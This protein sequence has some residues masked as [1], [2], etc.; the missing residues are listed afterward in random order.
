MTYTSHV[1]LIDNDK[2]LLAA[3]T[4]TLELADCKV[5]AFTSAI[6]ALEVINSDF[7]GVVIT[8]IRMPQLDG[9]EFFT[10][11]QQID[12][13]IPVIIIT[14]HGDIALA[15][16][17][18]NSG[19]YDFIAKPFATD[20]LIQS[21]KRA[22]KQRNL[23]LENRTMRN[24]LASNLPLLG[25]NSEI[26]KL[27]Q[28]IVQIAATDID[29]LIIGETGTGKEVVANALHNLSMRK[30]HK[31]V[32]LNCG[33]L[34]ESL[35]ESELF[36][37]EI[38]AFTGASKKRI[39]IIEYA[40]NGTLFL[41]EVESMSLA[42]QARM[43]R[44]L[45]QREI[46]PLGSNHK[47][48]L[49][50][51]I[52]AATKCDLAKLCKQG[53]F[54]EDL[55]YRLAVATIDIPPLRKR[56]SDIN[57]LYQHFCDLASKKFDLPIPKPCA[58]ISA[59]LASHNWPGNV[60]ELAHYAERCVLRIAYNQHNNFNN[61]SLPQKIEHYEEA[62]IRQALQINAGSVA[63]TINMLQIPRKTFYDK[64]NRYHINRT[65][66]VT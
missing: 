24:N 66:Y 22:Q 3:C 52:I 19:A 55:Y 41:D 58:K 61:L 37:H 63:K 43:L 51:R 23:I 64:L 9:L 29:V 27:R 57:L 30:D 42:T 15:V 47:I 16:K 40:N 62:L 44:V 34:A 46:M 11:L 65:D 38:G 49:N 33:S 5:Q 4:Q 7:T 14:G 6:N 54:R 10:K 13:E 21:V 26:I 20:H 36:G 35:L 8:D 39:G 1:I 56:P 45:E 12:N 53:L 25:N 2:E 32:S 31:M 50:L 48:K 59:Y 17:T 28:N 18:I 60:R